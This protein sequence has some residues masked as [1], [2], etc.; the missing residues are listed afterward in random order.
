GGVRAPG[1]RRAKPDTASQ[2][3]GRGPRL[4][5]EEERDAYADRREPRQEDAEANELVLCM[6]VNQVRTP[7][8]AMIAAACGFDAVH[9]DLEHD[10]TSLGK[11]QLGEIVRMPLSPSTKT[12]RASPAV[13]ATTATRFAVPL[14]TLAQTNC[15][16]RR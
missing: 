5:P 11:P 7:N 15:R 2:V 4:S 6:G 14:A 8:I 10:P 9:I 12:S 13:A 1:L 16:S 3:R